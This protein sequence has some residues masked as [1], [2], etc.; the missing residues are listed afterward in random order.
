MF[1]WVQCV[2]ST[3][4]SI[5]DSSVDLQRRQYTLRLANLRHSST[6]L[7]QHVDRRERGIGSRGSGFSGVVFQGGTP[8]LELRLVLE[9][10]DSG[11]EGVGSCAG[12]C[13]SSTAAMSCG[14]VWSALIGMEGPVNADGYEVVFGGAVLAADGY[15]FAVLVLQERNE[16]LDAVFDAVVAIA[17]VL[18]LLRLPCASLEELQRQ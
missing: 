14:G 17:C 7:L 3:P 2:Q 10:G 4:L 11:G 9:R 8:V 5:R 15:V 12:V 18:Y 13:G 16:V 6:R 1:I